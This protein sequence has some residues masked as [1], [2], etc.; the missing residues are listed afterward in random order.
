MYGGTS[1]K[2]TLHYYYDLSKV[3]IGLQGACCTPLK[4]FVC[5]LKFHELGAPLN[6]DTSRFYSWTALT[7][8]TNT[9]ILLL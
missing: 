8:S 6:A 9:L 7:S 4:L 5:G 3:K 2:S 1:L